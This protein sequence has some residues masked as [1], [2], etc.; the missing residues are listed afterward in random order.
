MPALS[1]KFSCSESFQANARVRKSASSKIKA[2]VPNSF[3]KVD[4][5]IPLMLNSAP[6]R[7]TLCDHIFSLELAE[8]FFDIVTSAPVR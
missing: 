2:G 6:L 5:E 7:S 1:P 4:A 8:L 3:A